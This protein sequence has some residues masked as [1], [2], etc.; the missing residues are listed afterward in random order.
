MRSVAGLSVDRHHRHEYEDCRHQREWDHEAAGQPQPAR[1][2]CCLS[3]REQV[4]DGL[5]EQQ[6]TGE[7]GHEADD[8]VRASNQR[9]P[10]Q[11]QH[12]GPTDAVR[13]LSSC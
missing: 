10:E 12:S 7:P 2:R 8:Q 5:Q 9:D 11:S 3:R 4:H 6:E 1:G 13:A